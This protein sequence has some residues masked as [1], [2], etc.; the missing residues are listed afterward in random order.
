MFG[1]EALALKHFTDWVRKLFR[2]QKDLNPLSRYNLKYTKF[3]KKK[4]KK[5]KNTNAKPTPTRF[6]NHFTLTLRTQTAV[7]LCVIQ[8]KNH[9]SGCLIY[10]LS[11]HNRQS[12]AFQS[13]H[14]TDMLFFC[15]LFFFLHVTSFLSKTENRLR[16][17]PAH[18]S[19]FW[20]EWLCQLF[21]VTKQ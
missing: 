19:N 4:K 7:D 2:M 15:F 18:H 6:P 13:L 14:Y 5:K 9:F 1:S 12:D 16:V 11:Q 3:D 8:N 17:I 10:C 21:F 20:L